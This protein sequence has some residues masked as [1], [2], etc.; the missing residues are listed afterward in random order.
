M[1][2]RLSLVTLGVRNVAIARA[3]Y[4]NILGWKAAA[5]SND[6]VCFINLNGLTL[7]LF[8]LD[9]LAKDAG[10]PNDK[11]PFSGTSLAYNTRSREEVDSIMAHVTKAGVTILKPAQETFWGG[12]AGYFADPDGY[13]WEIAWNP[14]IQIDE[15]GRVTF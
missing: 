9:A 14:F 13:A 5:A 4:E 1:E 10:V 12:Y 2:P 15:A 6:D 8:S 3:F 11:G 7:S